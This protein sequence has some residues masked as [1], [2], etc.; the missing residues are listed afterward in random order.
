MK[1]KPL[2]I[3]LLILLLLAAAYLGWSAY[4][5][6]TQG[7]LALADLAWQDATR[8][9]L[10]YSSQRLAECLAPFGEV[11]RTALFCTLK[12]AHVAALFEHLARR[13]ILTRRFDQQGLLRFGL[14]GQ[15]AEWQRLDLA[16][17][18][19]NQPC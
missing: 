19:W 4:C 12:T 18:E 5:A 9:R 11:N 10:A 7:R 13:A 3:L 15:E 14:P 2:L 8:K 6:A 1:S 16:L 17:A